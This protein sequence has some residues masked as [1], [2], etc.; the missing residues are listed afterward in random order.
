MAAAVMCEPTEALVYSF[1]MLWPWLLGGA[2]VT[3]GIVA[4]VIRA[5]R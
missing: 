4:V 2:L 1:C 5:K 3:I